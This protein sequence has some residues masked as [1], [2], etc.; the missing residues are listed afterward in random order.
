MAS[1][2]LGKVVGFNK[3]G[4]FIR[5][6][7]GE[8]ILYFPSVVK[9]NG[10]RVYVTD[11][12]YKEVCVPG[13]IIQFRGKR[14]GQGNP[15]TVVECCRSLTGS[16]EDKSSVDTVIANPR[17][18][19]ALSDIESVSSG[20]TLNL[21]TGE[22]REEEAEETSQS[23]DGGD[24]S[25]I[26]KSGVEIEQ[27]EKLRGDSRETAQEENNKIV[28]TEDIPTESGANEM[29]NEKSGSD[30]PIQS[31]VTEMSEEASKVEKSGD[32]PADVIL[33]DG[34][35]AEQKHVAG[36][37]HVEDESAGE[38]VV[39]CDVPKMEETNDEKNNEEPDELSLIPAGM[40]EDS[41]QKDE[42]AKVG[43]LD[44]KDEV[45][46]SDSFDK[47]AEKMVDQL[48]KDDESDNLSNECE[49]NNVDFEK[50]QELNEARLGIVEQKLGNMELKVAN[51]EQ[52][53]CN[54]EQKVDNGEPKLNGLAEDMIEIKEYVTRIL[55]MN[56]SLKSVFA[57]QGGN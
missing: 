55:Q 25:K 37:V 30:I 27:I 7:I 14:D 17:C 51:V 21:T 49:S 32:I 24:S 36:D 28:E 40:E 31:E 48:V 1:S 39:E 33:D 26:E 4:L 10:K 5:S 41:D 45:G 34:E 54:L 18:S 6:E 8:A 50:Y 11:R 22:T 53:L 9:F 19:S 52:T 56:E 38:N 23:V 15:W 20:G 43:R 16:E 47:R 29:R 13:D 42:N 44:A 2:E 3:R 57:Q 12:S 35:A 46:D